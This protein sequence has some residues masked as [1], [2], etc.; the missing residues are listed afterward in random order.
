M[1]GK[2]ASFFFFTCSKTTEIGYNNSF[3][4]C[5]SPLYGG[6]EEILKIYN[7]PIPISC[8]RVISHFH[9]LANSFSR[10]IT[11]FHKLLRNSFSRD[12]TRFHELAT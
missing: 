2:N 10:D 4:C 11:R 12:T 1:T 6:P 5:N 8:S 3:V 7:L 9:K